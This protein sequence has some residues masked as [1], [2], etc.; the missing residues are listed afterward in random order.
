MPTIT[1][2]SELAAP[3]DDV[4]RHATTMQGVN[5][6]LMPLVKMTVPSEARGLSIAD[7]PTGEVAFHSWLLLGGALPFDRHALKLERIEPGW[8]FVEE[9][10]SLMQKRWR[11][12]RTLEDIDGG[13]R[14]T[15]EVTVEPRVPFLASIAARIVDRIFT[16]RHEQL[17]EQFGVFGA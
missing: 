8:E 16:H 2:T 3:R 13:C 1:H 5:S 17:R 7:A 4:W 10:T 9:S 6:E 11:H 15:D 14:V 12:V